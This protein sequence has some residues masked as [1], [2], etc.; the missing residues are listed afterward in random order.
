MI[1]KFRLLPI[2]I[3]LLLICFITWHLGNY[4]AAPDE[5]DRGTSFAIMG[6]LGTVFFLIT[7]II[8]ALLTL[9]SRKAK[10]R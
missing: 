2:S 4:F 9:I 6:F 7:T 5:M 1:K 10:T 3:T 8:F